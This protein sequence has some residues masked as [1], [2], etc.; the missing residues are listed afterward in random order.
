MIMLAEYADKYPSIRM[1]RENGILEVTL[2]T[3]GDSLRWNWTVHT[4]LP[5]AFA[6]IAADRETKVVIITGAGAEFIGPQVAEGANPLLAQKPS[7]EMADRVILEGK[8]LLTNLLNIDVPVISAVNGPTWRHSAVALLADIVLASETACFQDSGHFR[9]GHVPG[10]GH[11]IV[12]PLLLG[13][14]RARY[15][16][17]TGQVI[18]AAEAKDLGLV[19]E[20]LPK[21]R[22]LPRAWELAEKLAAN[23]IHLLRMTRIVLT[24]RLKREVQEMIGYGLQTQFLAAMGAPEEVLS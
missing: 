17:L 19:A 11:H 21:E 9:A 10:D 14:N 18:S 4:E 15:F 16:L 1:Q 24:E 5:N 12:F 20:V 3:N 22:L 8:Q 7:F 2:H 23:P 6:D 13:W